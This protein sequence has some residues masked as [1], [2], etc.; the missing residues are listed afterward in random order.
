MRYTLLPIIFLF[1]L[2]ISAQDNNTINWINDNLIKI[3]N[4][5]PDSKL[6]IF[7]KS[8]P[9]KFANAK[10]F[11]FG[12]ATHHGREF[13]N[14]KA[15]F[16]KYLVRTQNVK[17]FIM[18]EAYPAESG[19]NEWISG[20][21]GDVK[22]I[23]N[24]FSIRV[25]YTREV[26]DLLKWMRNY[27]LS[28]TKEEPIRFYGMDIQNGK[29]I[30]Q[31]IRDFIDKNKINI[32]ENLLTIMDSCS[33]KTINNYKSEDW[34]Q[35]QLPKL[36]KLKQQLLNSKIASNEYESVIRAINYLIS[37][38]EYSSYDKD[39]Y[40]ISTQFRDQKMF[41]NVKWIVENESNN[42]K[43]FIWAHNEHINNLGKYAY[44]SGLINLGAH[45]KFFYKSDYYS[46][47]F[48]F[49]KGDLAGLVTRRNKPNYWDLYHVDK[50]F[51][52]TYAQTLM[53]A[54]ENIYFVDMEN[55]LRGSAKQFFE[56]EK[57]QLLTPS[58]GYDPKHKSI[59]KKK[60]SKMF[61]GLIFV[62]NISLPNYDLDH[63]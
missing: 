35:L 24:N 12:E 31:E 55:A 7:D 18:E 4:A 47:Y 52:N 62:K 8:I 26:L 37:Y 3:E 44:D 50:P 54:N 28:H 32:D 16:F 63:R 17:T 5:N 13:F 36:N 51:R 10:I 49:G 41:E 15:K 53:K 45:L 58:N 46:V 22:T 23:M 38:T 60:Y 57:K 40:P 42:H 6:E 9:E 27:N 14:I 20:G 61:D 48:D 29:N 59:I 56:D 1:T 11:G 43:A 39:E 21:E 33:N 19:I 2:H 25:W 30:N 34:W